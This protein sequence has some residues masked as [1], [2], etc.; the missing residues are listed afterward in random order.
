MT[1]MQTIMKMGGANKY[2][3]NRPCPFCGNDDYDEEERYLDR[4]GV[5]RCR[6]CKSL[7]VNPCPSQEVLNEY[8]NTS[9]SY[10]L[11]ETIYGHRAKKNKSEILDDRVMT[12]ERYLRKIEHEDIKILEVGCSNGGFLSRLKRYLGMRDIGKKVSFFG[13]DTNENAIQSNSDRE[14]NL[15]SDTAE[16]FLSQTDIRFDII[17]HSE[18]I[19]HII[20]PYF[21][22]KMMHDVM[23][24]G[25]Y[26]IFTTPN[27]NSLE[28]KNI[29]Y[30][31]PRVLGCNIMPPPHLN[32]FSTLNVPVFA[33]RNNFRI[34]EITT[35]G[36]FDVEIF[37][38]QKEYI[39][40]ELI[41]KLV[42]SDE[43][44]KEIYQ[45]LIVACGG[46]SHLQCVLSK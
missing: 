3:I 15:V 34:E 30:N 42:E 36:R 4:Y 18:L 26:M 27:D 8:Y 14:L 35:P 11:L 41:A 46:S 28:M 38:M 17:W 39:D 45:D 24:D 16:N 37:E 19:E 32:A 29:S 25:A 22:F 9:N 40:N 7:Y 2:F 43:R 13:V 1:D 44:H 31:V 6:H 12:I 5:A 33:L 10:K 20:D 23:N 21:L